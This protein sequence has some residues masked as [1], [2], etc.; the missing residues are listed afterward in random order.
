[1]SWRGQV[2][3]FCLRRSNCSQEE[4]WEP[5][6]APD[7]EPEPVHAPCSCAERSQ[8]EAERQGSP[9]LDRQTLSMCPE[10]FC[11]G[12]KAL[13]VWQTYTTACRC[14]HCEETD[15]ACPHGQNPLCPRIIRTMSWLTITI[16]STSHTLCLGTSALPLVPS[17]RII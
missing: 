2:V 6:A 7:V 1:M 3:Y 9:L 17:C 8:R 13:S 14:Q 16:H 5:L 4:E 11:T 15:S 10:K 12:C